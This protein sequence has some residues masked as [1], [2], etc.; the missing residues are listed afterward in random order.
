MFEFGIN[1]VFEDIATRNGLVCLKQGKP[2][3]FPVPFKKIG[4]GEK[5]TTTYC[6]PSSKGGAWYEN[7]DGID[8]GKI[9]QILVDDWQMPRQGINTSGL[10]KVFILEK[11]NW[12]RSPLGEV[13][14][15]ENGYGQ[16]VELETRNVKPIIGGDFFGGKIPKRQKYILCLYDKT[17]K[18]L[19]EELVRTQIRVWQYILEHKDKMMDRK[20]ILIQSFIRKGGFWS[21]MGVGPYSF[22]KYKVVW[23][24]LGKRVFNAIVVDGFWQGNQA[25]HAFIPSNTQQDAERLCAE[26]NKKVPA[27]L[28]AFGMAGT[29]NWAQPG[30]IKRI[31][32]IKFQLPLVEAT[33]VGHSAPVSSQ[34][35][36]LL[37]ADQA[38]RNIPA[39]S[40]NSAD[41]C[42][43]GLHNTSSL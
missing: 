5:E 29:C 3:K 7:K 15:F 18:I 41:I 26:L 19:S 30:R 13:E 24:A 35:Q 8:K 43:E 25:M 42:M 6:F 9:E 4:T 10:N 11:E 16:K 22:S 38:A 32:E 14:E 2:Q 21:L 17:G 20:G 40:P 39:T 33:E 27:Y 23:E 12:N 34:D 1:T 31:L 28:E 36:W 37:H